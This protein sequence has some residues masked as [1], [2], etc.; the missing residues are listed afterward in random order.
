[1]RG[2]HHQTQHKD[3]EELRQLSTREA[4]GKGKPT[5][6]HRLEHRKLSRAVVCKCGFRSICR[7]EKVCV[8]HLNSSIIFS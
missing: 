4:T 8:K 2:E 5:N 6:Y 1:M 3:E 7:G